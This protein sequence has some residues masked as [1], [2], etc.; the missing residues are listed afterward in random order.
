MRITVL[1]VFSFLIFTETT[2]GYL[3]FSG[4]FGLPQVFD[5]QM[6]LFMEMNYMFRAASWTGTVQNSKEVSALGVSLSMFLAFV[7]VVTQNIL[8]YPT[9]L[10]NAFVDPTFIV[11][12]KVGIFILK[13]FK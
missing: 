1:S 11:K 10:E 12:L 2:T 7:L 6:V 13:G 4:L 9:F 8:S 3:T 5:N